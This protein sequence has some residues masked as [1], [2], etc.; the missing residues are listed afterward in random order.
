MPGVRARRGNPTSLYSFDFQ[1]TG[2][3]PFAGVLRLA[4]GTHLSGGPA[5]A[6][7]ASLRRRYTKV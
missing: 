3:E 4:V 2:D 6:A 7:L 1:V 5:C